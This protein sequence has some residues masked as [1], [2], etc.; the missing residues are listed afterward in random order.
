ML[1]YPLVFVYLLLSGLT[2]TK[3]GINLRASLLLFQSKRDNSQD[4]AGEYN[5]RKKGLNFASICDL[6][7]PDSISGSHLSLKSQANIWTQ[8]EGV[9]I[10][11]NES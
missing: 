6:V 10:H 3:N 1:L 11:M 9:A 4:V 2:M 5:H 8:R 7:W